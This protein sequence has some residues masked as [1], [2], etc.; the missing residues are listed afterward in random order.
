M[1]TSD[2]TTYTLSICKDIID[3]TCWVASTDVFSDLVN[4]YITQ[5]GGKPAPI[6]IEGFLIVCDHSLP[7][8][9]LKLM[10][11]KDAHLK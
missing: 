5:H 11:F 7:E 2:R 4:E 10:Q 9:T 1:T 8:G 3:D 6:V